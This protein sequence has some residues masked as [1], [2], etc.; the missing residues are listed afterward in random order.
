M[1]LRHEQETK[2][3]EELT[4]ALF[5]CENDRKHFTSEL[6]KREDFIQQFTNNHQQ[7]ERDYSDFN[8]DLD[9]SKFSIEVR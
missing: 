1:K 4:N 6:A 7:P 3:R 2:L 9:T 8:T 5:D